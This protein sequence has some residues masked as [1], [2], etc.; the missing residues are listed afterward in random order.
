MK[1]SCKRYSLFERPANTTR[2][3]RISTMAYIRNTAIRIYAPAIQEYLLSG[4]TRI[5][6]AI[7]PVN[8]RPFLAHSNQTVR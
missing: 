7:R 8:E 6:R 4:N 1:T 2:W 3:T 5:E